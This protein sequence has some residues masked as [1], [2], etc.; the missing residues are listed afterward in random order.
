MAA[1]L[2]AAARAAVAGTRDAEINAV[3]NQI[4]AQ[5]IQRSPEF[6]TSLG[7]DKGPNAALKH[8]LSDGS[9]AAKARNLA[10]TK[11]AIAK[12]EVFEPA[13]LS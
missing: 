7:F 10:D 1:L 11:A 6:A 5:R 3:Y 12:I 8:R 4:V 13:S 2:P 9:A